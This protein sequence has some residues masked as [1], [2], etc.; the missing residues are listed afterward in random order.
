MKVNGTAVKLIT[1]MLDVFG[2]SLSTMFPEDINV[3]KV[4]VLSGFAMANF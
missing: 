2:N 4:S 1:S 3:F